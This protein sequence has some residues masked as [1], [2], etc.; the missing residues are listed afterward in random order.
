MIIETD[1][2]CRLSDPITTVDNSIA[3]KLAGMASKNTLKRS[4]VCF[5]ETSTSNLQEMQIHVCDGSYI[6]PAKHLK[7]RESLLVIEG[8]AKQILFDDYGKIT[9]IV[10]LGPISSGRKYYYRLNQPV[11]HTLVLESSDFL[12]HE[13]TTGPFIPSETVEPSWSPKAENKDDCR[14][15]MQFLKLAEIG[16]KYEFSR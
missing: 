16:D 4:R 12:F 3:K 8:L 7:K 6:R 13:V 1:S 10:E 15:F 5:H 9:D 14:A 11:F 2:V